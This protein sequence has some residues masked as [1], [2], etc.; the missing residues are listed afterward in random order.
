MYGRKLTYDEEKKFAN[1]L[2]N[3]KKVV[4][5]HPLTRLKGCVQ[6]EKEI[7]EMIP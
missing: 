3:Q 4:L 7:Y 6:C 5:L 1:V 2:A